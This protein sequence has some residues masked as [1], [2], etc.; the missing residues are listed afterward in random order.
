MDEEKVDEL[1]DL[2]C[3]QPPER[4]DFLVRMLENITERFTEGLDN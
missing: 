1:A 4:H 2:V 3:V